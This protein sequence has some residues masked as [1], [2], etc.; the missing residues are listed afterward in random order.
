[1]F[2]G[3]GL[4]FGICSSFNPFIY[5]SNHAQPLILSD[6]KFPP[7][8]KYYNQPQTFPSATTNIIICSSEERKMKG[9]RI[10]CFLLTLHIVS[11][12]S[13]ARRPFLPTDGISHPAQEEALESSKPYTIESK[14]GL[15]GMSEKRE[16][17]YDRG[18]SKI[19]SS[20]PSCE[21]KCYGCVPCE[22]IQ[23]PS[24]SSHLGIQYANYELESWKCKCGPSFYSP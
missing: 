9:S 24:T 11:W 23:V 19:G 15:M 10:F 22:A 1:M 2:W 6:S 8:H 14:K 7:L 12:V 4:L 20:P 21:H 16:E 3:L 17:A 18:M 5:C 13:A